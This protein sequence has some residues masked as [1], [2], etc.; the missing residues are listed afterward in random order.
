[1]LDIVIRNTA[2]AAR[3][4]DTELLRSQGIRRRRTADDPEWTPLIAGPPRLVADRVRPYVE[5]GVTQVMCVFRAP[6]DRET[7]ER[8]PEVRELL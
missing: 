3:A 2:A 5:L 7:I 8:L 6:W 1:M 4:A